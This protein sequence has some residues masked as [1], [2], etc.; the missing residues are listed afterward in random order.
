MIEVKEAL[1]IFKENLGS[2]GVE[3]IPLSESL[4]RILKEDWYTDRP[5]PPY[6]RVAMDGIAISFN[7]FKE[8]TRTF[9]ING[10]AAAGD[11]QKELTA[12]HACLEVMTGSILPKGCDA[13]IRYE[14]LSID[15]TKATI[16]IEQISQFQNIHI[17]ASDRQVNE[18]VVQKNTL[19]SAAEIG[20]GA[21]IGKSEVVVAKLP[22]AI[23]IST[24][25]ELVPID[26]KPLAHQIRKSNV[27]RISTI[28][29][30]LK[31]ACDTAHFND[32][33]EEMKAKLSDY[34]ARY[35]VIFLSGAV[36]KGKFDFLP[37][38]L[39]ELGAEK[40]FHRIAQRPGKPFWFGKY[41]DGC[42]IFAF[43]G[44]PISS[45]MCMQ[46]YF[47]YWL[48]LSLGA[49]L[50]KISYAVLTDDVNFKPDLNYFMEVKISYAESGKILATPKRGGGS[51]DLANL[52]DADAFM[53]LP[54]GKNVFNKGE[55]YPIYLYR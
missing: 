33:K 9:N 44:N 19:I 13:V 8:D 24:G 14:D 50:R 1:Q 35:D 54:R 46:R 30:S 27:Y 17:K 26:E 53:E 45:F 40:L 37:E 2:F 48:G 43:P 32:D 34:L 20:L 36:S 52:V 38:V 23:V 16:T 51:G 47:I 5:L 10:V 18:L 12:T 55:I 11:P 21:S 41:G 31:I 39:D 7:D 22:S 49:S 4:G 15:D 28:L 6:D 42:H 3:E 25:N 29:E